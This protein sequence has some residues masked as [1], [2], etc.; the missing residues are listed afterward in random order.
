MG[1]TPS[2]L[3]GSSPECECAVPW[4]ETAP[5]DERLQFI[6]VALS[7]RFRM[8]ELCARYGISRRIG[9]SGSSGTPRRDGADSRTEVAPRIS[10]RIAF[11]PRVQSSC[12]SCD[13]S[14]HSGAR[15]SCCACWRLDIHASPTGPPLVPLLI[16]SRAAHSSTNGVAV[17]HTATPAWCRSRRMIRTICGRRTSRASFAPATACIATAHHR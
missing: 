17:G 4:L 6:Q 1:N 16:C 10:V 8:S 5:M 7:D 9:T 2:K 15:G 12:A 11:P 13:D 3:H 14:T